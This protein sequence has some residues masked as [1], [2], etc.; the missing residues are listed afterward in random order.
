MA[1]LGGEVGLF[2]SLVR[3][4]RVK[5]LIQKLVS[6]IP[7]NAGFQTN[8]YLTRLFR[9]EYRFNPKRRFILGLTNLQ[10]ICS[11]DRS[12]LLVNKNVV[13]LG[14]GWHGVDL[15][16]FY[17]LG[18]NRIVTIDHHSHL[19]L[20]YIIKHIKSIREEEVYSLLVEAGMLVD[21]L[22]HLEKLVNSVSTLEELLNG[23]GVEY[24]IVSSQNYNKLQLEDI[25]FFYSES[26]LQRIPTTHLEELFCNVSAAMR[27]G[28]MVFNRTDQKDVNALSHADSELWP[29]HYLKYSDFFFN[30]VLSCRFNSQNRLR[31]SEFVKIFIEQGLQPLFVES[32]ILESDI[33]R[34]KSLKLATRFCSMSLDDVAIRSSLIICKKTNDRDNVT[35]KR[36]IRKESF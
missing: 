12:F 2:K 27:E 25:D 13:E 28:G 29:L 30:N 17:L 33:E 18:A 10:R 11:L 4:W 31:E 26:V 24:I 8:E 22:T 19:K 32:Y 5:I 34:L 20:P 9:G 14:T 7:G 6:F 35:C 21:R 36:I 1:F 23:M 15:I 16:L 3:N